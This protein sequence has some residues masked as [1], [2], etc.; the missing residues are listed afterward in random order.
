VTWSRSS[1]ADAKHSDCPL[2]QVFLRNLGDIG[3]DAADS[4]DK[5]EFEG[6][7]FPCAGSTL[8]K[9]REAGVSTAVLELPSFVSMKEKS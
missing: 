2:T 3:E 1:S 5:K 4:R 9:S 8:R 7:L 6:N